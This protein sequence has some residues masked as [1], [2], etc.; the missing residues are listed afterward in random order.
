MATISDK[1]LR[2]LG[3]ALGNAESA[4]EVAN[5]LGNI[6]S[7]RVTVCESV[8]RGRAV[9]A[10][11]VDFPARPD[12]AAAPSGDAGTATGAS[13]IALTSSGSAFVQNALK[14]VPFGVGD[15]G[16]K[17]NLRVL[18]YFKV[19]AEA[20]SGQDDQWTWVNLCEVECVLTSSLVGLAG[21]VVSDT[22]K[23][24]DIINFVSGNSNVSL[25]ITTPADN[26]RAHFLIDVKGASIVELIYAVGDDG[27]AATSANAL[28]GSL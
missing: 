2:L 23:Y 9:N 6:F 28:V 20:G 16:D 15:D 17:F 8:T 24:C 22:E 12:L 10:T 11:T 4:L 14:I 18:G 1:S 27:T 25:E 5:L 26:S 21:C 7:A 3:I 13:Y 19:Q